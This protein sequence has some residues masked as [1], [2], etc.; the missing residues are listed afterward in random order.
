MKLD[1]A[2]LL[3][4]GATSGIAQEFARQ[5]AA[6]DCRLVLVARS[7]ARLEAVAEDLRTRGAKEVTCMVADLNSIEGHTK[8]VQESWECYGGIDLV[9]I[10]YGLYS[11]RDDAEQTQKLAS[12]LHTNFVSAANLSLRVCDR[13]VAQGKGCLAVITS[14][15]GDRGRRRNYVY[16]ASKAGLSIFLQGLDH[17]LART[18]VQ[19]SDIRLGMADTPM[20]AHLP[21]SPLKASP[22]SAVKAMLSGLERGKAVIYAP[23]YW[24]WIMSAV[25]ALPRP[26]MNRLDI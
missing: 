15:A 14:V 8:L 12:L 5:T 1:G 9:L 4:L 3:I 7:A 2:R 20:T 13:F 26:L 25:R 23:P 11:E 16:G 22:R 19:V 6:R 10:A 17:K 18:P 21:P 24:R